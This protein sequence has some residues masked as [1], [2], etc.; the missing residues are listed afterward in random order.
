L[1]VGAAGVGILVGT[2]GIG[3]GASAAL[4]A[5]QVI[6]IMSGRFSSSKKERQADARG[7]AQEN[8]D[9][10][11]KDPAH[12]KSSVNKATGN[13]ATVYYNEDGSYIV[14]DDVTNTFANH[15]VGTG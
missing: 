9:A 5:A 14:K 15:W 4:G 1:A 8:I 3:T 12:T 13:S 2:Q 7:W 10:L 6:A 11:L